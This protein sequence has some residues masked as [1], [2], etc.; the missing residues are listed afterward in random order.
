M[1]MKKN[2]K[3]LFHSENDNRLYLTPTEKLFID[4]EF[5]ISFV[6]GINWSGILTW[7]ETRQ[8]LFS[9]YKIIQYKMCYVQSSEAFIEEYIEENT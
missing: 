4:G 5:S 2:L 1:L 7:S 3:N 6:D 9:F 8:V